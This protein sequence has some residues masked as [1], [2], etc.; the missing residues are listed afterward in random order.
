VTL[1]ASKALEANK[2]L[3]RRFVDEVFVQGSLEAVDEL[4]AD[5]VVFHSLATSGPGPE[6]IKAA[7]GRVSTAL[8]ESTMTIHDMI[9]E[10]DRVAVRLTSHAV[11]VGE[12]MG[13]APSGRPFTIG[14]IHI[15]RLRDGKIAEHWHEADFVG[16]LRQLGAMAEH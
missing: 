7:I 8:A 9:A 1:E 15:F 13:L 4:V 10:E 5:D 16:M 2:A 11:Q 14:E 3:V 12:F 6:A